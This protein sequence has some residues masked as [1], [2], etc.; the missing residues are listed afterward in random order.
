MLQ[1]ATFH[2]F[3]RNERL[4]VVFTDFMDGANIGMAQGRGGLGLAF[5]ATQ[6]LRIWSEPVSKELQGNEAMEFG[7]LSLVPNTH[8]AATSFSMM[9]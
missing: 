6:S 2:E 3:H 9:R 5:E 8:T 1:R 4:A 7:V